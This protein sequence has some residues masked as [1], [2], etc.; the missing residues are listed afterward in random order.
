MNEIQSADAPPPQVPARVGVILAEV[1]KLNTTAL[2]YLIVHLNTLQTSIEF[3][4]LTPDAGDPLL[5]ML[6]TRETVDRDKCREM[7][8]PFRDRIVQQFQR[9]QDEYDLA[10]RSLP[11]NFAVISLAKFHD[12]HYGLKSGPVHVQALGNWD[13]DMAPPSV[14]EFIVGCVL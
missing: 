2:K 6:N 12:E 4:I 10:D 13:G 8:Y 5:T 1:Q 7:L 14:F 3:E 11:A 9:E